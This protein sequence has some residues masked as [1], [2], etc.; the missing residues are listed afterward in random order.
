MNSPLQM[1]GVELERQS[2][3]GVAWVILVAQCFAGEIDL[4]ISW[5]DIAM[6]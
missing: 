3:L 1:N 5:G 6:A 2:L 4:L